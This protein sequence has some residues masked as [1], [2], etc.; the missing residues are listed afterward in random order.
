MDQTENGSLDIIDSDVHTREK[1]VAFK[2]LDAA[3]KALDASFNPLFNEV[4]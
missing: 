3:R 4:R 2:E 1:E